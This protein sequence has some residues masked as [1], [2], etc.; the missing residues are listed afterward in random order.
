MGDVGERGVNLGQRQ[1][2]IRDLKGVDEVEA[3]ASVPRDANDFEAH[4]QPFVEASLRSSR[5]TT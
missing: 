1:M 5:R 2:L 4:V 3:P